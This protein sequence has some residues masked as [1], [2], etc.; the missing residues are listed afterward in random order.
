MVP[1]H[2]CWYTLDPTIWCVCVCVYSRVCCPRLNCQK[3]ITESL[4]QA[5]QQFVVSVQG[6]NSVKALLHRHAARF[7]LQPPALR[8]SANFPPPPKRPEVDNLYI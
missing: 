1:Q 2:V 8:P 4:K 5:D 3:L 7:P 6:L